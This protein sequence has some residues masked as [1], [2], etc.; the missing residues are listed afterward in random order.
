LYWGMVAEVEG[1]VNDDLHKT[2]GLSKKKMDG[3]R[4][5]KKGARVEK[6]RERGGGK[7]LI[8]GNPPFR[9][10]LEKRRNVGEMPETVQG[11]SL[12]AILKPGGFLEG[13]QSQGE[14]EK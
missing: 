2:G 10:A 11:K 9:Y 13:V 3:G 5:K 14:S 7:P 8:W 6:G 1:A 4:K 12:W